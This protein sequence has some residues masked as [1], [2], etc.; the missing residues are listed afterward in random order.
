MKSDAEEIISL[1]DW[2]EESD[3]FSAKEQQLFNAKQAQLATAYLAKTM[4]GLQQR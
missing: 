1:I 4:T 2:L 3:N